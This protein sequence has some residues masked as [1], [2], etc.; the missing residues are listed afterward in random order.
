M[1]VSLYRPEHTNM[2]YLV[3]AFTAFLIF[4]S[5]AAIAQKSVWADSDS[6]KKK[7]QNKV[8][9]AKGRTQKIKDKIINGGLS[10][11]YKHAFL[12]GGKL[13]SDGWSGSINLVKRRTYATN[14]YWQLYFSEIKHEKQ[15]KEKAAAQGKLPPS[16]PPLPYV[17][18]K[19]NNLYTLQV[20]YGK[21]KL[22][23]PGV[24]KGNV[25]LSFRYTIGLSL[26]MLKPYYL[27]L[28]YTDYINNTDTAH[29]EQHK[30]TTADSA[31]FLKNTAIYG[32]SA[33][34]KGLNE[35]VFVPGAYFE[36]AFAITPG[37]PK[38]FIQVITL[39]INGAFYARTLP[40]MADQKAYPWQ[41]SMFA[42]IGLGRRWK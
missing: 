13:N 22:L 41:V 33:W 14:N 40:I 39:G 18:G 12:L 37:K 35:T 2:N 42:G 32:A 24:L 8:A 16:P 3:I 7:T 15:V 21:E 17:F 26:A 23:L 10:E 25:S 27:K 11:D 4:L 20:G 28:V 6:V 1:Q 30:F 5:P 29:L 34:S 9:H 19:I 31:K 36:T 38:Y